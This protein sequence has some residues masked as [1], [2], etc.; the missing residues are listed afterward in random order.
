M[1]STRFYGKPL[2]PIAGV[3]LVHRVYNQ[4]KKSRYIDNIYVATDS[5][6]IEKYCQNNQIPV[7][8]TGSDNLVCTDRVSEASKKIKCDYVINIQGDEPIIEPENLDYLI[9]QTIRNKNSVSNLYN[10]MEKDE[11]ENP[12]R[13]KAI[14]NDKNEFLSIERRATSPYKQLGIYMYDKKIIDNFKGLRI[15]Y[16]EELDV[17]RFINNSIKVQGYFC[18]S[19]SFGVDRE[20]DAKAIEEII[21]KN[22]DKYK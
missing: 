16:P 1:A 4:V 14:L 5:I 11:M 6:D 20:E 15:A 2:Y 19:I 22:P 17:T 3:P 9:E 13:V 8:M 21:N 7:I 10:S 18:N 12:D